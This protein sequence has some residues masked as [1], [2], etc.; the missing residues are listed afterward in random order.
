MYGIGLFS[1][2]LNKIRL[3]TFVVVRYLTTHVHRESLIKRSQGEELLAQIN[4][5]SNE[6]KNA[7]MTV[8][9][10]YEGNVREAVRWVIILNLLTKTKIKVLNI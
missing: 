8:M 1:N 7:M 5:Q 6:N 9:A 2:L 3:T 4:H 10:N